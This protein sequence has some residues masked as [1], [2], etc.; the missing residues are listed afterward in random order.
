MNIFIIT[1]PYQVLNAIEARNYFSL[2]DNNL[3][4]LNIGFFQK[5]AFQEILDKTNWDSI[6]F[7]DFFIDLL[8]GILEKVT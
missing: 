2:S 3:I 1:A 7:I 6:K 8:I 5:D 4:I